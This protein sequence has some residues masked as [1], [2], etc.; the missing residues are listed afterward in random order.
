MCINSAWD[1][2]MLPK[3]AALLFK[4]LQALGREPYIQE[5][6][7]YYGLNCAPTKKEY[8]DILTSSALECDLIWK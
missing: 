2:V 4:F 3:T 8:I 5:I 7:I 1:M 6:S